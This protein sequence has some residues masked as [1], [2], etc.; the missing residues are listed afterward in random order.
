VNGYPMNKL[1]QNIA[2][3]RYMFERLVA[4]VIGPD[5]SGEIRT[6]PV[7]SKMNQE[8][9]RELM[10]FRQESGEE[11]LGE[12]PGRRFG[13]AILH[14][15][16]GKGSQPG[17]VHDDAAEESMLSDASSGDE[18]KV[19][20]DAA[21]KQ[22]KSR[23]S[24]MA[25]VQ[26]RSFAITSDDNADDGADELTS[27]AFQ[28]SAFGISVV[29][30]PE[31][32]DAGIS[33]CLASVLRHGSDDS[34]VETKACGF[35][36]PREVQ[37][38]DGKEEI[39]KRTLWMRRSVLVD[40]QYPTIFLS[41][42]ELVQ[43]GSKVFRLP[44]GFPAKL[45]LRWN[46]RAW[47]EAPPGQEIFTFTVINHGC[48]EGSDVVSS[49]FQSGMFIEVNNDAV[50]EYP[51]SLLKS[52]QD[53]DPEDDALIAELL[54]HRRRVWAV[55]HGC[56]A[57][58][59]DTSVESRK[60]IWATFMPTWEI[61][62][63]SFEVEGEDGGPLKLSMRELAGIGQVETKKLP[64]EESLEALLGG[65]ETWVDQLD[66]KNLPERF[67]ETGRSLKLRCEQ[68][69]TRMRQ[70]LEVLE[71]NE[72]A[73]NA[74]C[75]ANLSMLM[76]Q[77]RRPKSTPRK[78]NDQGLPY[79]TLEINSD[80]AKRHEEQEKIGLWR[81]FQLAFLLMSVPDIISDSEEDE[82]YRNVVD[83]IWFPTG[84]GKTEAYLGLAAFTVFYNRI[85]G[86]DLDN[87]GQRKSCT[88]LMRYTLRLLTAQQFQRAVTLFCAMELLRKKNEY[89][90]MLTGSEFTVG[91][92][93]GK[94]VSPNKNSES[95]RRLS[96]FQGRRKPELGEDRDANP[97]LLL[98]C[99][100][101]STEFGRVD[102]DR[103]NGQTTHTVHG[104]QKHGR[105]NAAQ[106]I[107][108]C[109]EGNCEFGPGRGKPWRIPALVVDD[110]IYAGPP[111]LL[112]STVDKF[113]QLAWNENAR[114]ILGVGSN[115]QRA[116]RSP[117]LIIQDE[118]HLISG[119]LGTMVGH[120]ESVVDFLC[121]HHGGR[122]PKIIAS[123][124]TAAYAGR[125]VKALYARKELRV[126][127]PSGFDANDSYFAREQK[128]RR[129]RLYVGILAPNHGSMQTT[130]RHIYAALLQGGADLAIQSKEDAARLADPW[131]TIL[132]YYN[133]I[134][135]LG[136]ALTLF[137][138]DVLD[139]LKVIRNRRGLK[140]THTRSVS[141][142]YSVMELTSRIRSDEVPEALRMLSRPLRS[143]TET[144][145][146]ERT[147]WAE[148]KDG[149]TWAPIQDACLASN[150]IEVGVDVDRLALMVIVG[151][152]KTTSS[153]IQASSRVGRK[154]DRPG[155]V[156]TLY[157]NTKPRDRSHFERFRS[158]HQAIYQ[159][160]EPTSVTPFS[161]PVVE[162]ALKA[163]LVAIARQSSPDGRTP[164]NVGNML[165]EE[166]EGVSWQALEDYLKSRAKGTGDLDDF[167]LDILTSEFRKLRKLWLHWERNR[168]G[169]PGG[170][171]KRDD[172]KPLMHPSGSV[173]PPSWSDVWRVPHSLRSVDSASEADITDFYNSRDGE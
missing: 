60:R 129:G 4:E 159:R 160:V 74:F 47:P 93:A 98:Q 162:R 141:P 13:A 84:G 61:P 95:V 100:W 50:S 145:E 90:Q 164:E 55:G 75:L 138:A 111:S 171:Y 80:E 20:T 56:S 87:E 8:E 105:G 29:L 131:W 121:R 85:T 96:V 26:K 150:M 144:K 123:T 34:A 172:P 66:A 151:Q 24:M 92:W 154:Q 35:Y 117:E 118:L 108:K 11:V 106:V 130:Q 107:F 126:F 165:S 27:Q 15:R 127:P 112:I 38:H 135:E 146:N 51:G 119:P 77:H 143:L 155:L 30:V 72:D 173:A 73:R 25:A 1:N 156:V 28:P 23:K 46:R 170:N 63:V 102:S 94:S 79:Q 88:I 83:L 128:D 136:G 169:D 31:K 64:G 110:Q 12:S 148:H 158:F 167:E 132:C 140:P 68:A 142:D 69:L 59:N 62:P 65:Y 109:P 139:Q 163:V 125:Q 10:P 41:R 33:I 122:A 91:L 101:C 89:R 39:G 5:P 166:T 36:V 157:A 14:P 53:V 2:N 114:V 58:W 113:A 137:G 152:P 76:S 67:R 40:E 18:D 115:G 22:G 161:I 71:D 52:G 48:G 70:G 3:R 81:P 82:S 21:S 54:Y 44:E 97:F 99:P 45:Q 86:R 42:E 124:A 37:L 116:G 120:F 17:E 103:A 16:E 7:P 19:G 168:W 57:D 153:Y 32:L 9:F 133:S 134:R 149:R 104:Y 43:N 147:C 49:L 6:G 78:A